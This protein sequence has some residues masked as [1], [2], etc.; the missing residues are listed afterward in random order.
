MA[1]D[2]CPSTASETEHFPLDLLDAG[3]ESLP[4]SGSSLSPEWW[5]RRFGTKI[6]TK[7]EAHPDRDAGPSK[8]TP[9]ETQLEQ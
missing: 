1:T 5:G 7:S 6:I 8:R 3:R 4:R 2:N 9:P